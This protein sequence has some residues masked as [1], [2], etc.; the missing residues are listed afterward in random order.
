M[1]NVFS[2][3]EMVKLITVGRTWRRKRKRKENM[4]NVHTVWTALQHRMAV[5]GLF[6]FPLTFFFQLSLPKIVNKTNVYYGYF[7]LLFSFSVF[8]LTFLCLYRILIHF[9]MKTMKGLAMSVNILSTEGGNNIRSN[10]E[11]NVSYWHYASDMVFSWVL[12]CT[13]NLQSSFY[14]KIMKKKRQAESKINLPVANLN[15]CKQDSFGSKK[16]SGRPY[17]FQ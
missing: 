16:T 6:H 8:I 13:K 15:R 5:A 12:L 9:F 4:E 10:N 11:K 3:R 1:K 7:S 17:Y 2:Y 14:R